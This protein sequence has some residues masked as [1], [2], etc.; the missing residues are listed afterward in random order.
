MGFDVKKYVDDLFDKG[1]YTKKQLK[2]HSKKINKIRGKSGK[3]GK[4]KALKKQFKYMNKMVEDGQKRQGKKSRKMISKR[5]I[6]LVKHLSDDDV[7]HIW[8]NTNVPMYNG[9]A[10]AYHIMHRLDRIESMMA[11]ATKPVKKKRRS[12]I[13]T[14]HDWK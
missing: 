6:G 5:G 9:Y 8:N 7:N 3:K 12:N 1:G 11:N 13:H 14:I 10:N 4:R 2:K